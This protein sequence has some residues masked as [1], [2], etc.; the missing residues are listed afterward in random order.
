MKYPVSFQV[1]VTVSPSTR[2]HQ[3]A[4][5]VAQRLREGCADLLKGREEA[6]NIKV[7]S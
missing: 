1:R 6:L 4:E 5:E 7:K 2:G 3:G